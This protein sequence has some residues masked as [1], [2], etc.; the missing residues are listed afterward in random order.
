MSDQEPGDVTTTVLAGGGEMGA[1][2]RAHNWSATP[3]GPADSWPQSLRSVVSMLLP[4]KAQIILFWGPE[5][6]VLYNDAYRPVFGAK[7]PGA[8]GLP[9]RQAWSEIWNQILH[10]LLAGVVRTG[11]A[12]W[13]SDL[14]FV[15]ERHGFVEETYFDVSY[16]PVRIESGVVGGV[17]CIVT[18]TTG[19]V[20]AAQ[21]M[22]LL[23]DLA[24]QSTQARTK[25]DA[26]V[27]AMDTLAGH[28]SDIVFALAYLDGELQAS[29]PQARERLARAPSSQVHD[30]AIVPSSIVGP[31]GRLVVGLNPRRPF[32]AGQKAFIELVAHELGTAIASAA[33][34]EEEKKRAEALAEID[35]AKTAFFSN[36][37]H[38]FRTPLTLILG[39]VE[40]MLAESAARPHDRERV[41]LVHRNSLR[42]LKLVNTLLDFSRIE[43][44]RVQASFEPTD[45]AVF[46]ADLS[47]AFRSAIERAAM[48]LVV[49]CRPVGEPVYVDRDMWEKVVLNLLSNAF[50]YTLKGSITVSLRRVADAAVLAVTDTG[51][52]I[53]EGELHR[54][55]DRFHRIEGVHGRTHE[56]TG[57]GLALVKELVKLHGGTVIVESIHGV[58]TT[59][60]VSVPLG[61]AHLPGDHI[62]PARTLAQ[63]VVGASPYV[64][65]AL[66]WLPDN[67]RALNASDEVGAEAVLPPFQRHTASGTDIQPARILLADDNADMRDYVARMLRAQY[68]VEAV[69]DGATALSAARRR[70][71][72]L[73]L[74]D[75]MMPVMDG[76]GLLREVRTDP[77]LRIVPLL[78]LS[79]R[80]GE[81]ARVEGL[82]AGADDYL[83]KPFS[84]K[85]LV[86]R[87]G[88]HL[89][90]ARIRREADERLRADLDAMTRL[91]R[92]GTLF[93]SDG[94]LEAILDEIVEA[95]IAI[96][97]ADFGN[98]QVNDPATGRVRVAGTPSVDAEAAGCIAHT[99]PLVSRSG[100][101]LGI[102][103]THY[104]SPLK[105]TAHGLRFLDLLG[106]QAA[107]IVERGFS[108]AALRASEERLRE[109]DRRK[110]EFL[111]TLAHELRNPLAPIRTGLELIRISGSTP[112]SI[113]RV[114]GIMERQVGHMVRLIDDL[115][116]I[117]RITS[118]KIQL[119]RQPTAL[120]ELVDG[121]VEA[122]RAF[123]AERRVT[124]S[125]QLPDTPC[126]LDVD[127]TR[128]VQILSNLLHN[129]AKFT[130]PD[131]RID[132]SARI[133]AT[134][135]A[136]HQ[137]L[138]LI[139]ADTGIGISAE[140]LPY[141]F[142]LF[143]QDD[144]AAVPGQGG[145]GIG[146][147]LVRRLVEMH[148]GRVD[149][150]SEGRNRGTQ[151]I[152]RLPVLQSASITGQAPRPAETGTLACRVLVV[153]DNEDAAH[154][155]AMLVNDLGGESHVVH[156]GRSGL[157]SLHEFKP[158]I[159]LLDIGMPGLD[160]YETCRQIREMP[161]GT[162]VFVVALTGWGQEDDK[163]RAQD[164]GFDFHLT[165]PADPASVQRLLAEFGRSRI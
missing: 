161:G 155:L 67:L 123:I 85:E 36:V 13:A 131:G 117:S 165:K 61:K 69:G 147:A 34:H 135:G 148:G 26:C 101:P 78:L 17:Y 25:R 140:M 40:D 51:V 65:E 16:D 72:D 104:R 156:D 122:T 57:I 160:G 151:L 110:D 92:I 125:V 89:E 109:T 68:E 120:H 119:Q 154:T 146:L 71:P 83:V 76:F 31:S 159:V 157:E 164:A 44:G 64:E 39:P 163:Q 22:A 41:E 90:L 114:R 133:F 50:K 6:T 121:A 54:V 98:I 86:A 35:R 100:R 162:D 84:A 96:A 37:S 49:D 38:E 99:T 103:S 118:G 20:V 73:I 138:T 112:A 11:E 77:M 149:A 60:S 142:D 56:G 23:K 29:T 88:T 58:G 24:A 144:R 108:E 136:E 9:G 46:T 97:G 75:V 10:E 128:F 47:S 18:E 42:L 107:D 33:A 141:V 143:T 45:L 28:Q 66:R 106:R 113:E 81:E 93:V 52:G 116:D 150:R 139:V 15:L 105:P 134:D 91:Q 55:F 4:S 111:A 19:R 70:P 80:A 27:I 5:F 62:A 59:F 127:R 87:V 8:L 115:L 53:P 21:R 137:E 94:N 14:L 145:L 152:I 130:E 48:K 3:L 124:L 32:D 126:V 158:E 74:A 30:L 2:I 102:L 79:A 63:T 132:V 153:D 1:R 95:A 129:A 7:H 43:A 82:A 12:F